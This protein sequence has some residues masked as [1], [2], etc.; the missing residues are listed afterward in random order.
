MF[1][2]NRIANE[3]E[4]TEM[5]MLAANYLDDKTVLDKL[6]FITVDEV[7]TILARKGAQDMQTVK[8][9]E[10]EDQTEEPEAEE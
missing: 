8:R 4:E 10:N 3:K 7:D 2:R 9:T 5:V 1:D 6:P